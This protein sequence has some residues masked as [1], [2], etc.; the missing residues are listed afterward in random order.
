M[1]TGARSNFVQR[2][3]GFEVDPRSRELRS[4]GKTIRLQDQPLEVLLLLL[5]R[6]GEVVTRD[7]LKKR[8]WPA[9]TFVE[10]DDG[11][12]TAVRKLREVLGDSPEMPIYIETIPRR[13]Y[14]FIGEVVAEKD[15]DETPNSHSSAPETVSEQ[16]RRGSLRWRIVGAGLVAVAVAAGVTGWY[17]SHLRSVA[18]Q[19]IA[20]LPFENLSADPKQEYFADAMT[21]ELTSDLGKISALRV[22]SRT[23][24]MQYRQS[25]KRLP[26]I[27]QEL[28]VDGV[29]EGSVVRSGD[30]VRITAQ[31]IDARADR[32]MWS[33]S[34]ERDVKDVLTLQS[35]LAKTIAGQVRAAIRPEEQKRLQVDTVNPAAFEAYMRG[36]SA[37]DRWTAEDSA[38]ALRYFQLA[39]K[40]NPNYALAFVG[41]AE[42]YVYGV[43]G[44]SEKAALD[45]GFNAISQAL[46]LKPDM[47]EAH[48]ILGI[49]LAERDWSFSG[50]EAELKKGIALS[51]NFAAA[52]H[53]Y[54][55]LLIDLGRY[56][57]SLGETK[58][59][60]ELDP[61]SPTPSGHL[62][63]Q[64]LASRQW[65]LAIDQYRKA[66]ALDPA[67]TGEYCELGE[68]YLGKHMFPEAIKEIKRSVEM[69]H[70]GSQQAF[71]LAR[72][73]NVV[74]QSGQ[75]GEA[76]KI[77]TKLPPDNPSDA[78]YVYAGLG[79]RDKSIALLTEAYRQHTFPLDAGHRVEWDPLRSDPR[80]NE[81]LHRVGLR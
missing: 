75:P 43:A 9:D 10:S 2:F 51:P 36:R 44:V 60:M 49:L 14:R 54:S 50:A 74:A 26:E 71:Y 42:C 58:K 65:D 67:Q 7:E 19:S 73:G 23:S 76:M 63:Y 1:S 34:Y 33:E 11:I 48:A 4:K 45:G 72:L 21:E 31:L 5:E 25:E 53:T 64:Y 55:H 39:A 47:G 16:S 66:L 35:E 61:V 41:M 79:E 57:E 62:A 56:D 40:L 46:R 6:R 68:A 29:I 77:L 37:L 78:A 22:I 52:H 28:N 38:E 80:F 70:G 69:S 8:L 20:V 30:R 59:F 17:W 13:G 81:L 18:I 24:A 12:N 15:S 3:G 27:A 32:H